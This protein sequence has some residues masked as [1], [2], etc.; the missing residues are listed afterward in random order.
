MGD[1]IVQSGARADEAPTALDGLRLADAL[2][3]GIYRLFDQTD[4]INKINVFPVPDGDTG[5]NL[6][7]TLSAVLA[8]LDRVLEPH[9]GALLVRIADAALDGAR[10]NSGAILAQFLLG[11][12]D[13]AGPQPT[14]S[15]TDFANAAATGAAYARDALSQPREGT[16][17]TVLRDFADELQSQTK[18]DPTAA[19]RPVH[20]AALSRTRLSLAAT[21]DQLEELRSAHVVDAG[22]QGFVDLLE[23]IQRY[24]DTGEIGTPTAAPT[25]RADAETMADSAFV[26]TL[27]LLRADQSRY[28][29][30]C[31]VAV[32]DGA[33]DLELRRLREGLSALGASLVVGGNK[34]KAKVHI[35][36]DDPERVF[37]FAGTFGALT[38]QKADDMQRQQ[39]A[40]HHAKGQRVAIVVDSAADIPEE[41]LESLGI[42]V[43]PVRIQFGNRSYLDKVTMTSAEFYKEL[44]TNPEHPKTSQPPPGD[45]R[46]MYEFLA[47][48]YDSIVS[49]AL[50]SKV[51]GTCNAAT[52]A[53]SRVAPRQDGTRAVTVIDSLSISAGQALIAITAAELAKSG[54]SADEVIAAVREAIPRTRAFALLGSVDY[55]V[56]GGRV[57]KF[58]RVIANLLRL[59]IIL[60]TQPDGRVTLSGALWGRHHL[61]E[62]FARL[63]AK[64]AA[65][66]GTAVADETV[67]KSRQFRILIGH[68]EALSAGRMLA[69]QLQRT[70]PPGAVSTLQMTEMGTA[71]GVHGGPGTLVVGFQCE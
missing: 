8:A 65:K 15:A 10:G 23:G 22:A 51:S 17:L 25:H 33:P 62:R 35:H 2:R 67:S 71:L 43:V 24:L 6:S 37:E 57:P 46:R 3:A 60:A 7:M 12:A 52:T 5:T 54:A 39:D 21:T 29:T 30:E 32:T 14:L 13:K 58:A 27:P 45:F 61:T 55:A 18:A 49:I 50:S 63:V 41:L 40:A 28:C 1:P 53:A 59:S 16:L 47:S 48:H 38:G 9:A 20:S 19:F 68:G 56:K 70:L 42:H 11:L 31:L 64:R 69:Q 4:H 26:E 44:R 36:T 66:S 34:R